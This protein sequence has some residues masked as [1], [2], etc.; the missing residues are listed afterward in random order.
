MML[1]NRGC[2]PIELVNSSVWV[3]A[4]HRPNEI[5]TDS[6]ISAGPTC[7]S[8][9]DTASR[10]GQCLGVRFQGGAGRAG[11]EGAGQGNN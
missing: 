8:L 1:K 10:Q 4:R 7:D 6:G 5:K 11:R 9:A 3:R 2:I